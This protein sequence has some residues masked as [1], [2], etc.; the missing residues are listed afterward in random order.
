[1]KSGASGRDAGS[2]ENSQAKRDSRKSLYAFVKITIETYQLFPPSRTLAQTG[3]V[4]CQVPSVRDDRSRLQ[5]Y[6]Y[7]DPGQ[8]AAS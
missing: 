8:F 4:V 5:S 6:G 3:T 2:M 7:R 1:M